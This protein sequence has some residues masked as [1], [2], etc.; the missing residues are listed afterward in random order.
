MI[1]NKFSKIITLFL[2][3]ALLGSCLSDFKSIDDINL[4]ASADQV[5]E[6]IQKNNYQNIKTDPKGNLYVLLSEFPTN[7]KAKNNDSVWVSHEVYTLD[8]KLVESSKGPILVKNDY[9]LGLYNDL[10]DTLK[11]KESCVMYFSGNDK[12]IKDIPAYKP[13]YIKIKIDSIINEKKRIEHYFLNNFDKTITAK[14][15]DSYKIGDKVYLIKSIINDKD[16]LLADGDT[17]KVYYKGTLLNKAIF[18]EFLQ[19][20]DTTRLFNYVVNKDLTKTGFVAGFSLALNN[21]KNGERGTVI[22]YS[23]KAYGAG[24]STSS[25]GGFSG[26]PIYSPLVFDIQVIKVGKLKK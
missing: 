3:V 24:G 23:E 12:F 20:S 11:E 25:G 7:D 16:T 10:L 13:Y 18:D 1:S 19:T 6:H 2:S 9:K 15:L 14:G 5:V 21:L 22:M 8:D 26:I 4:A 17:S